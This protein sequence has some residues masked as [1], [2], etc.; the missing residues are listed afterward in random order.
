MTY[1]TKKNM[2]YILKEKTTQLV[3]DFFKQYQSVTKEQCAELA[4]YLKETKLKRGEYFIETG[5]IATHFGLITEGVMQ[6]CIVQ[7]N[8]KE[9][10]QYFLAEGT[11]VSN[12]ASFDL[13]AP[14]K[15]SVRAITNCRLLTMDF[16]TFKKLNREIDWL[17]RLISPLSSIVLHDY[18]KE[19]ADLLRMSQQERYTTFLA[20]NPKLIHRI[21]L[22][23]VASYLGMSSQSLSRIR[24]KVQK[25]ADNNE[26]I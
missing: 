26:K 15:L 6:N 11:V 5:H 2:D 9:R 19:Y 17:H 10:V 7:N 21:P 22:V 18:L 20:K 12:S 13:Q 25:K 3:Y 8:G 23:M 4:G 14:S 1:K 16:I 24:A